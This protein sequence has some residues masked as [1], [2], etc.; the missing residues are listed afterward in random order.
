MLDQSVPGKEVCQHCLD[1]EPVLRGRHWKDI[2]NQVHNQIQSQ[3]KQQFH[4]QMDLQENQGHQDQILNQKKQP[5]QQ[6]NAQ[7]EDQD[8]VQ[9]QKK[10]HYQAQM[11]NRVEVHK[12]QFYSTDH[13]TQG[14]QTTLERNTPIPT[15]YV[16]DELHGAP[17]QT[18]LDQDPTI[19]PYAGPHQALELHM[20]QLLS[21]A[22]WTEESLSPNYTASRQLARNPHQ[23]TPQGGPP[24]NPHPGHVLF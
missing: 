8:H 20:H 24:T 1:L 17:A 16:P 18:L 5:E 13:H 9:N 21:R 10:Q 3:K 2:K 12:K 6:Y 19:S 11:D 22:T 4:A 23:D 14:L 7:M 15:P